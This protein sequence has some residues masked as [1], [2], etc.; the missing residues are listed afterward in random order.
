MFNVYFYC[1]VSCKILDN[2]QTFGI[3]ISLK[4]KCIYKLF[5]VEKQAEVIKSKSSGYFCNTLYY[6]IGHP[7]ILISNVSQ[8]YHNCIDFEN[9]RT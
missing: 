1:S 6:R 8:L 7:D 9:Y 3:F 4:I 2:S 5:F